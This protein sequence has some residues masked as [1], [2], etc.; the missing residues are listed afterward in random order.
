MRTSKLDL[1]HIKLLIAH[2]IANGQ[3]QRQIAQELNS[4]QPTISR[5]VK[6]GDVHKMIRREEKR[7]YLQVT[8][9]LQ[10]I[11][12]DPRFLAEFQRSLEKELF[13]FIRQR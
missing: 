2:W 8:K 10:K 4:S 7:L 1:P 5:F 11:E 12:N 13:N 6:K 9:E 3:S